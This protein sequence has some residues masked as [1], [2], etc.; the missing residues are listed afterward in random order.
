[1]S[2]KKPLERKI[3]PQATA[4]SLVE[5]ESGLN[6]QFQQCKEGLGIL[7]LSRKIS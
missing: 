2:N 6:P 5:K 1:M 7:K 3:E 4:L